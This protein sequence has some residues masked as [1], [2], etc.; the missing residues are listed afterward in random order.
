MTKRTKHYGLNFFDIDRLYEIKREIGTLEFE[1]QYQQNP[2]T[3]K[4]NI[5]KRAWINEVDELPKGFEEIIQSW[6]LS[7]TGKETSDYVVG[8]IWGRNGSSFYLLDQIRGK[9][10]FTDTINAIKNTADRWPAARLILIEKAANA[11]AVNSQLKSKIS[12]I[13][14]WRP[15]GSKLARL[16][17]VT[18]LFEAG[19][20]N[21]L[22]TASFKD[23]WIDEL[24]GF[25]FDKHD[26]QV[27]ATTMA[28]I[29]LH[30]TGKQLSFPTTTKSNNINSNRSLRF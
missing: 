20:V 14:L 10:D 21:V 9:Y 4:G 26:D 13:V 12:G 19:N 6:D 18:P 7:F 2:K 3:A 28:L 16:N 1:A 17:S 15:T 8:Q 24:C 11:E 29:R 30:S 25:P 22:K 23:D 27:D 5:V